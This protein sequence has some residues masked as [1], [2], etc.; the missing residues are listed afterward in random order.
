METVRKIDFFG[1]LHG[2]YLELV[3]NYFIDQNNTYDIALPQFTSLGACHLKNKNT[4]Y[5][6]ITRAGH[7]SSG[8][9]QQP[10][11][12]D[13]FVI[14]IV[15][16]EHDLLIGITN[17]FLRAGDQHLDLQQLQHNTHKKLSALPKLSLF[18]KT[19]ILNHG[20]QPHYPKCILRKYF[21]A[22]FDDYEHGLGMFTKWQP[23]HKFHN[24]K[25]R[26][27]FTFSDFFESLQKLAKFVNMEFV[28]TPQLITLHQNFLAV[29]QGLASEVK[30]QQIIESIVCGRSQW[31]DLNILEEAWINYKISRTFNLYQLPELETNN[32]PNNTKTI[33]DICYSKGT[34]C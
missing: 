28:P 31:I 7:F 24:F 16:E 20:V 26:S 15:P 34:M 13:D 18:L 12:H 33:S 1:G 9:Y 14:R 11:D 4:S 23:A 19:L 10:F 22:M 5:V 6:P 8:R 3:V 17:S 27:F 29:N 25:F 30:C 32:Y 21:Y 2:N